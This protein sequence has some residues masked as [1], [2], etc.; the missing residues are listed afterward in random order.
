MNKNK[1]NKVIRAY[2]TNVLKYKW[3]TYII[4]VSTKSKNENKNRKK[5]KRREEKRRAE[6]KD[7]LRASLLCVSGRR[8]TLSTPIEFPKALVLRLTNIE[9]EKKNC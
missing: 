6:K 7:R 1:I 2:S 5:D 9:K 4:Y 3:Q 8:Y